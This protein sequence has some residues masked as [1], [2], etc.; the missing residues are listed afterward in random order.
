MDN[1]MQIIKNSY[2]KT[3]RKLILD[4]L[5]QGKIS[6][7]NLQAALH[8]VG[9]F[10][11]INEWR[12]FIDRLLLWLGTTFIGAGVIYFF[13]YN[14]SAMGRF[15]KFA[16]I[17]LIIILSLSVVW[18][19]G[20]ERTSGKSAL[21]G[22]ALFVGALLALIGQTYQTGTDTFELFSSWALLILPWVVI[23]RFPTLWTIWLALVNTAIILYFQTFGGLFG[24]LFSDLELLW[25]LFIFNTAALCVWKS[26]AIN[27]FIWLQE[28]WNERLLIT[29]S[30]GLVTAIM[31]Y[32]VFDWDD[33][34]ALS[35]PVW[36]LWLG[37]M[38]F[39][40]R[41][42]HIDVYALACNASSIIVVSISFLGRELLDSAEAAGFLILG[43]ITI[44]MSSYAGW[45]L[46]QI[47]R[48]NI[49]E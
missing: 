1:K 28:H 30:A 18:R 9:V 8:H 29:A 11:A 26:L 47:A 44:G 31:L 41:I 39:V 10:P 12:Q 46:K 38:H 17:E 37:G 2:L 14:W 20:I 25:I 34:N 24:F 3:P 33:S 27:G 16:L 40:Y 32:A 49:H 45:W 42:K 13:A 21:T 6:S 19:I 15:S 23:S 7:N 5:D 48:E 35:F 4:W 43:L 36:L 22:A